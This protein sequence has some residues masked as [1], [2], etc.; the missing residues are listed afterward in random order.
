MI[1]PGVGVDL[2]MSRGVA[3]RAGSVLPIVS[4]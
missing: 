4:R 1:E 3:F 2:A